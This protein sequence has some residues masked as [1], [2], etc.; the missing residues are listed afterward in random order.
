MTQDEIPRKGKSVEAIGSLDQST[1]DG[2]P[3][4]GHAQNIFT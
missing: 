3:F 1:G 4:G 2:P